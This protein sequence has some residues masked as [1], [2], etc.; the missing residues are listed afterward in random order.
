MKTLQTYGWNDE[1]AADWSRRDNTDYN[2]PA[3]II[4]DYGRR[5]KVAMPDE[6][7]AQLSGALTHKLKTFDMPKIGDW[8]AIEVGVDQT[9]IIQDVLPRTSEIVRGN[10]G[11]LLDKQ[12]V[13]ANVDVAFIVQPLDHDFSPER[14]ERYLFQLAS[15]HIA[16]IILLNK[17]DKA[18]DA[19]EKQ[20]RLAGLDATTVIMSALH[21]DNTSDIDQFI[22]PGQTIVILGSSGAGKS[23]LTNRLL[24]EERQAT[25]AIRERDSKGRHTTVHRELFVL[26]GGGMVID[27]PGIRELQLWGS[28]EDLETLF[29]EIFEAARACHYRNCSHTNEDRC[30]V[31]LGLKAGTINPKRYAT[32]QNFMRELQVLDDRRGFIDE[33]RSQQTRESAK[34]RHRHAVR[35]ERNE[36]LNNQQ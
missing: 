15:Q 35:S 34:R 12:V 30:A 22:K 24:G 33:R 28:K 25:Q 16:V 11:K 23:T 26:P 32:Y 14:L 3:R 29:P 6:L 4:A 8:V 1:R 10:A 13:A 36:D 5:Y 21:D 17:S 19:L 2:I 27:T 31:N 9:A 7:S 20:A 18:I